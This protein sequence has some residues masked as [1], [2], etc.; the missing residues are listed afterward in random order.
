MPTRILS[1]FVTVKQV[2][3]FIFVA[4]MSAVLPVHA[5][6]AAERCRISDPNPPLKVRATPNGSIVGSLSNGT[7]VTVLDYSANKQWVF[8]GKYEDRSPIG[9]VYQQY[10]NCTEQGRETSFGGAIAFQQ[11]P[12]ELRQHAIEV[13]KSCKELAGDNRTFNDMHGIEILDLKGH[14]SRDIIVDNEGLC[15][16]HMAGAN[17]S[18]RACNMKI[19]KEAPRGQWH[20]I[21]DEDLYAKFLAIDWERMRFQLMVVSIYAGDPRCRPEPTREYTSGQSCNLIVTYRNN[22]WNWQRIR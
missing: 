7:F 1:P 2:W 11:L 20:K 6:R 5:P 4:S 18:N 3:W 21:F 22:E 13:R 14:G 15:G 16:T 19:Y 8:V 9:W 10:I 12:I 17:C